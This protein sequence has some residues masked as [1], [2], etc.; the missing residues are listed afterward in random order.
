MPEVTGLR[1]LYACNL[2]QCIYLVYH[3]WNVN[4]VEYGFGFVPLTIVFE[5]VLGAALVFFLSVRSID[6]YTLA[7]I[8]NDWQGLG[9]RMNRSPS[10]LKVT[11]V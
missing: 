11:E 5:M 7:D 4:S 9:S 3:N 2:E 10:H 8:R 1:P 6:V